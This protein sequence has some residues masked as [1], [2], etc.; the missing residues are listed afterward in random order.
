MFQSYKFSP[1]GS[2]PCL[3]TAQKSALAGPGYHADS[4]WPQQVED[5]Y[6]RHQRQP[7]IQQSAGAVAR[8]PHQE[9][10]DQHGDR[11]QQAHCSAPPLAMAEPAER[12][13][14]QRAMPANGGSR[15]RADSPSYGSQRTESRR[16]PQLPGG[17]SR[18]MP[19]KRCCRPGQPC[20]PRARA[21]AISAPASMGS[22]H[23]WSPWSSRRGWSWHRHR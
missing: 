7:R 4:C 17:S 18:R 14:Y 23:P 1:G 22:R 12:V 21:K 11:T 5:R 15:M 19:P 9:Y 3:G 20:R 2:F 13:G 16:H 6:P 8:C 10:R